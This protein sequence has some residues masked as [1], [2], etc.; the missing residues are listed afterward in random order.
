MQN[1]KEKYFKYKQKYLEL[2]EQIGGK[3][4]LIQHPPTQPIHPI[5]PQKLEQKIE[6]YN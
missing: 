2:K 1:Y 3:L 4:S 6:Q 5:H